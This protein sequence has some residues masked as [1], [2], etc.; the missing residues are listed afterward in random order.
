VLRT[1]MQFALQ[2]WGVANFRFL[3]DEGRTLKAD[4]AAYY[5]RDSRIGPAK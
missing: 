3:S 1:T 2:K 5:S 4:I